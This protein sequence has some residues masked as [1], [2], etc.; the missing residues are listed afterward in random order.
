LFQHEN[1]G[2]LFAVIRSDLK[3]VELFARKAVGAKI[4]TEGGNMQVTRCLERI[5]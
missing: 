4:V 3:K 1:S 2:E 5:R